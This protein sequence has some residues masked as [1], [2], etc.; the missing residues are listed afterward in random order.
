VYS[1]RDC[2]IYE[3]LNGRSCGDQNVAY[4]FLA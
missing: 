3:V 4:L 2:H 1:R